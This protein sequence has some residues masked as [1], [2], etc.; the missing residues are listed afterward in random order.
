[1]KRITF[2][3]IAAVAAAMLAVVGGWLALDNTA[4][5]QSNLPAPDN[6]RVTD[7]DY[8]GEVMVSWDAVNGA[9]GYSV[10][11]VNVDAARVVNDAGGD[12]TIA[13]QSVDVG[14]AASA[15]TV[16]G[17]APGTEYSF[18]VGS[19]SSSAVEPI[20]SGWNN[21]IPQGDRIGIDVYD[22][23]LLQSAALNISG[24]ANALVAA[25]GSDFVD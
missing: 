18:G 21:L 15:L 14:A 10:R 17:L 1:M 25:S 20:W 2:P 5:A 3:V 16:N 9:A 4:L 24:H 8:T 22:A 7:G 12:W 23:A 11:W 13:I 6:V 19:K